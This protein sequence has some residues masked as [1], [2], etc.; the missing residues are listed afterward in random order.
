MVYIIIKNGNILNTC[1]SIE[2]VYHNILTYCRIILYCDKN[3]I[4]YFDDLKI[5]KYE[6]SY[7]VMS[8]YIDTNTIDLFDENDNKIN[9]YNST[10]QRNK[11]ELEVLFKKET[12]SDVNFLIPLDTNDNDESSAKLESEQNIYIKPSTLNTN[13]TQQTQLMLQ[14]I[15]QVHANAQKNIFINSNK[16][17]QQQT[18][19]IQP[20]IPNLSMATKNNTTQITNNQSINNQSINNQPI[21][22]QPINNQSNE[23]QI[24]LLK[25]KIELEKIKLEKNNIIYDQKMNQYLDDKHHVGLI[26]KELKIK[27]E[28]EEEKRRVFNVDKNMYDRLLDEIKNN[29]RDPEDIPILFKNKFL[30][31]KKLNE[32]N[33]FNGLIESEQY[34]KYNEIEKEL[35]LEKTNIN[36]SYTDMFASDQIYRQIYKD[37]KDIETNESSEEISDDDQDEELEDDEQDEQDEQDEELEDDEQDEQ[38]EELEDDEQYDEQDEELEDDN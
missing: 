16:Q 30:V 5:I 23:E 8:Y 9:I 25:A 29:T 17:T 33:D 7:P 26:E 38:D 15:R 6:N 18:Q 14:K 10:I 36:T 24:K 12:E 13:N 21:N 37:L 32:N 27:K 34:E 22:N 20:I 4:T 11:M 1:E 3:K 31:F 19:Q 28:K 2:C 35:N